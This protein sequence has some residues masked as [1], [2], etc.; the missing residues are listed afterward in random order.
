[1]RGLTHYPGVGGVATDGDAG[2]R[3]G[4]FDGEAVGRIWFR[5]DWLDRRGLDPTQCAVIALRGESMEP[6]ALRRADVKRQGA[7]DTPL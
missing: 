7:G 4:S 5:R 2:A 1:M 6:T 3:A